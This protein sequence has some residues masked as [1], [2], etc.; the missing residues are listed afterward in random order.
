MLKEEVEIDEKF[1]IGQESNDEHSEQECNGGVSAQCSM[2][3]KEETILAE[4][5]CKYHD[6]INQ[7]LCRC[8]EGSDH[9]H[10]GDTWDHRE[11]VSLRSGRHRATTYSLK[12]SKHHETV[13]SRSGRHT[14]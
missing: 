8:I 7:M 5:V 11:T 4:D 12:T 14:E 2:A 1:K 6:I 3:K 9:I 13:S 10:T